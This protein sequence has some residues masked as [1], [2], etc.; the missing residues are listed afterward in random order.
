MRVINFLP[1]DYLQRRSARRANL[2]CLVL[3]VGALVALGAL[4]G[5][6]SFRAINAAAERAAIEYQCKE[7]GRQIEQFKQLEAHKAGLLH[8]VELSTALLE[9]VPRSHLL[10][11]LTNYLPAH[12]SLTVLTMRSEE[13]AVKAEAGKADAAAARTPSPGKGKEEGVK[14]KQVRFRLDGLA[15]TDIEVAEFITRLNADPLFEDLDLQ[16]SE[17]FPY[18]TGLTMRRFQISFRLSTKADRILETTVSGPAAPQKKGA[19]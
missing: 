11:R 5:F 9:R 19:S 3:G 1:D 16:F 13:V 8:K 17:E 7:A 14:V 12:T 2:L 6:M 15:Q 10:A 18:G 4:S